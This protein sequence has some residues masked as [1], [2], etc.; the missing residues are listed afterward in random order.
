MT[1]PPP[2]SYNVGMTEQPSSGPSRLI[3][4]FITVL[5]LIVSVTAVNS[6]AQQAQFARLTI[7]IVLMLIHLAAHWLMPRLTQS[8]RK[9]WYVG[10]QGALALAIAGL[11]PDVYLSLPVF[12]ALIG[13]AFGIFGVTRQ[14]GW[15][16]AFYVA[17]TLAALF[18]F[19]SVPVALNLLGTFGSTLAF[20]GLIIALYIRQVEVRVRA[21]HLAEEL[22][23]ANTQLQRYADQVEEL[24]L[25]NE[26]QR[27]ARELHDTLAQGVAG[28]VMQLEAV[29]NHLEN[30][31]TPR[32]QE[33][34]AQAMTRARSTL[35]ESR[36]AI[37]DL[38]R[39]GEG[40]HGLHDAIQRRAE[41]F[42]GATGIPCEVTFD[43]RDDAG[44][45][46]DRVSEHA[47][48]IAAEALFNTM[49]HAK[50]N[51]VTIRVTVGKDWL[52][53]RVDDD[54]LGFDVDAPPRSGHYGLLGMRERARLVG[55]EVA[56]SGAPGMGTTVT[57]RLP[58]S[59]TNME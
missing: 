48:Y 19:E 56:I 10:G 58:F 33:I 30:D 4:I 43:L 50:A 20:V 22:E 14:A 15:A 55:G 21:E 40:G 5:L 12:A 25:A 32:A 54:G 53:L 42:T 36:A 8:R 26:R 44:A 34:V 39:T 29:K 37:D 23:A 28:L 27:M 46:P 13:E 11:L 41:H 7:F 24:T 47:E 3:Y 18:L 6:F 57:A 2:P 35:A 1:H 9:L 59:D 51:D 45:I 17:L 31:R 49:R 52:N 16:V 38:R